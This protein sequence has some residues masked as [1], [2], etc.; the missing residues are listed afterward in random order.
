M[1]NCR[2]KWALA[3]IILF[4]SASFAYGQGTR[5]NI[6]SQFLDVVR[7]TMENTNGGLNLGIAYQFFSVGDP[8]RLLSAI[9]PWLRGVAL[10]PNYLSTYKG[11][12]PVIPPPRA[13][14]QPEESGYEAKYDRW[15]VLADPLTASEMDITAFHEAVHAYHYAVFKDTTIDDDAYGGPEFVTK[16]L[17]G[18]LGALS[19][20]DMRIPTLTA[21]ISNLDDY[22]RDLL[23]FRDSVPKLRKT[24]EGLLPPTPQAIQCLQN[25]GGKM[26]WDGY[27]QAYEGIFANAMQRSCSTINDTFRKAVE[28]LKDCR[29]A[30]ASQSL[31]RLIQLPDEHLAI[32]KAK[33]LVSQGAAMQ[34][35]ANKGELQFDAD[36][37]AASNFVKTGS[38]PTQPPK[39]QPTK[40]VR[41]GNRLKGSMINWGIN[42][43]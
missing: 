15:I 32:C 7:R 41:Q 2:V 25:I 28:A 17:N 12:S 35:K 36:K 18:V 3:C 26:D 10:D 30:A 39:S 37:T 23:R 6:K 31:G 4:W 43:K 29:F 14:T 19:K 22:S 40:S 9:D 20:Y 13:L 5:G 42:S 21:K 24:L 33:D 27:E 11:G 1:K 38:K 16:E 34:L 8:N